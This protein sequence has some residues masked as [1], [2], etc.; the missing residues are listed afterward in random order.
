MNERNGSN[1]IDEKTKENNLI[2]EA[3][4][5]WLNLLHPETGLAFA[6]DV[7]SME[8]NHKN[9][10]YRLGHRSGLSPTFEGFSVQKQSTLARF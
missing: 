7:D 2:E 10:P 6:S 4:L 8:V 3:S 9:R 5:L 1:P